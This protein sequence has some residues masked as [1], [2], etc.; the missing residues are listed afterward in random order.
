[1]SRRS[2]ALTDKTN[3]FYNHGNILPQPEPF[4]IK[5]DTHIFQRDLGTPINQPTSSFLNQSPLNGYSPLKK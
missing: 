4:Q 2:S 5:I 3:D 1:L